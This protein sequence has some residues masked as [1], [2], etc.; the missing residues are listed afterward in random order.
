ME[1]TMPIL[2]YMSAYW[3]LC[4]SLVSSYQHHYGDAPG[5]SIALHS[6]TNLTLDSYACVYSDRYGR[7]SILLIGLACSLIFQLLFGL[8]ISLPVSM[9]FRFLSGAFNGIDHL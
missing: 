8:S 9:V 6:C 5:T 1:R 4:S 3:S 2:V 7:R